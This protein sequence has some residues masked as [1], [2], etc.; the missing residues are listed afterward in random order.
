MPPIWRPRGVGLTQTEAFVRSATTKSYSSASSLVTFF[1]QDRRKL[2]GKR[3]GTRGLPAQRPKAKRSLETDLPI[4]VDLQPDRRNLQRHR[5]A[6]RFGTAELA[7]SHR[8]GN[9]LLDL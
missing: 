6:K 8:L 1:W 2:P 5:R 7:V 3:A 9:G 4:E